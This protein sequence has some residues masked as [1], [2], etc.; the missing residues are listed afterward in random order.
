MGDRLD[1]LDTKLSK[2][3]KGQCV[4]VSNVRRQDRLE[5]RID[6]CDMYG[7]ASD[8][9]ENALFKAELW[10]TKN[11]GCRFEERDRNLFVE[12]VDRSM[13]NI[14]MTIP[15]FKKSD[16]KAYLTLEEK[17]E[18][19]FKCH[20]YFEGRK[21]KFRRE[22]ICGLWYNLVGSVGNI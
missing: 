16:P 19:L 20:N 13:G 11:K 1:R 2:L 21:L 3:H 10:R 4:E 14:K 8:S 6:I 7:D 18:L 12:V 15:P 9:D 17:V 5:L 22:Y